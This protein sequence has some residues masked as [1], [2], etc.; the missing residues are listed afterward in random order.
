[1]QPCPAL[2]EAEKF[3]S[4]GQEESNE[5]AGGEAPGDA[6]K[7]VDPEFARMDQLIAGHVE[8]RGVSE[9]QMKDHPGGGG[10]K[11]NGGQYRCVQI[12]DDL[13]EGKEHGRNRRVE[14]RRECGRSTDWE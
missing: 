12:T 8:E 6:E 4:K 10:A 2:V 9:E 5:A 11:D 1:M 7:R 3:A 13:L 14:G